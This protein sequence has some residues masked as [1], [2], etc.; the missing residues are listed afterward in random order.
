MMKRVLFIGIIGAGLWA[1]SSVKQTS[2]DAQNVKVDDRF[3]V[4]QSIDSIVAPYRDSVNKEMGE[5]LAHSNFNLIA[6]RPSSSL[7]NWVADAVFANQTKTVRL[8]TPTFCLLNT[9]GIRNT[10]NIGDI[11]LGD[12]FKLM[13]FDNEIVWV[14]FPAEVL[15][16]IERAILK[17]GGEPIANAKMING[18]LEINGWRENTTHFWVITSD[19]L[20]KGGDNMEFFKKRTES[21]LT[22]KLMRDALIT[23]A[24][25]QKELYVDTTMRIIN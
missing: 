9:G 5:V 16:E 6:Q 25:E 22:G 10:L 7:M 24:R 3:S 2:V 23:E 13:P 15:P 12:M 20:M 21:N 18:K 8:S 4:N 11:T 19:Y 1:C 17:S 14:Q